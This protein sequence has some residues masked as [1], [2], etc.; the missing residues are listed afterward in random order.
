MQL[1]KQN[2]NNPLAPC[3]SGSGIQED[4]FSDASL[5][6]IHEGK[7]GPRGPATGANVVGYCVE[8]ATYVLARDTVA[9]LNADIREAVLQAPHPAKY[10]W[11]PAAI[12]EQAIPKLVDSF[13]AQ[14]QK[15]TR[16]HAMPQQPSHQVCTSF[17][18]FGSANHFC[19]RRH[20]ITTSP[21]LLSSLQA[22]TMV[23]A[24]RLSSAK[25]P[26]EILSLLRHALT[27]H[28][29]LFQALTTHALPLQV[30]LKTHSSL[31]KQAA[32]S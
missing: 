25:R 15:R 23:P 30:Q 32:L 8:I 2:C 26:C 16:G 20:P 18:G 14:K 9:A 12:L 7:V 11:I 17:L 6:Y 22:L 28:M 10:V 27:M 31:M 19:L 29:Q 13:R 4:S 21:D 24:Q 1:A 5:L 3:A